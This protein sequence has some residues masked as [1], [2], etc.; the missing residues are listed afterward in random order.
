M[1]CVL[2]CCWVFGLFL[3]SWEF[4][5]LCLSWWFPFLVL[6]LV[7]VLAMLASYRV[8]KCS[9]CCSFDFPRLGLA[10]SGCGPSSSSLFIGGM[11]SRIFSAQ[12]KVRSHLLWPLLFLQHLKF[13]GICPA[14][15][16]GSKYSCFLFPGNIF[17]PDC[18]IYWL[19]VPDS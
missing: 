19:R 7:L 12:C 6:S 2:T 13:S 16:L 1:V 8:W 9:F 3:S 10:H 17:P 14:G 4:L 15:S 11:S 18:Y 5:H